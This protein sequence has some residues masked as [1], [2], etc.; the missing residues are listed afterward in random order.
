[1][2]MKV[3][4]ILFFSL[5][6]YADIS[7]AASIK[8][9]I[10][11]ENKLSEVIH[12]KIPKTEMQ[13]EQFIFFS[14]TLIK[15]DPLDESLNLISISTDLSM[16]FKS[17]IEEQR[18]WLTEQLI[19]NQLA[20]QDQLNTSPLRSYIL[21]VYNNEADLGLSWTTIDG[22]VLLSISSKKLQNESLESIDKELR[23]QIAHEFYVSH[24]AGQ[25]SDNGYN[26]LA[27]MQNNSSSS[28]CKTLGFFNLREGRLYKK[29]LI[30]YRA[31]QFEAQLGIGKTLKRFEKIS[32][33]IRAY[34]AKQIQ[35]LILT[36]SEFFISGASQIISN[37]MC[38]NVEIIHS[39][40]ISDPQVEIWLKP[41]LSFGVDKPQ[42][43]SGPGCIS[44]T[45]GWHTEESSERV[46]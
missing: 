4:L 7:D 18:K 22:T 42:F 39:D 33:I 26:N 34:N 20:T 44:C 9:C 38:P 12:N 2:S 21:F 24:D 17:Y 43:T 45:S 46:E 32:E 41:K 37:N 15:N 23:R 11:V 29:I 28:N 35:L 5:V 31:S 19:V 8:N 27:S 30:N 1:M 40:L 14:Q 25:L 6:L 16:C 36:G 13:S 10:P 3:V